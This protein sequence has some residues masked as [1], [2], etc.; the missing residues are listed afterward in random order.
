MTKSEKLTLTTMTANAWLALHEAEFDN[1]SHATSWAHYEELNS[2]IYTHGL[3]CEWASLSELCDALKIDM[4][5]YDSLTPSVATIMQKCSELSTATWAI[6]RE[7]PDYPYGHDCETS[8]ETDAD[9]DN[10]SE[11]EEG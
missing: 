9:A 5:D 11:E 3:R 1:A 8:T 7:F 2:N 6:Y 4:N 10:Q